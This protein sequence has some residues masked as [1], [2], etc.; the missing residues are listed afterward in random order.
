MKRFLIIGYP[1]GHTFSPKMHNLALEHYNISGRYEAMAIDPGEF[2]QAME[3]LKKENISGFNITVPYKQSILNHLDKVNPAAAAIG[4]V[5]TV[6]CDREG[7]WTGYNTDIHGFLH[8]LKS[9]IPELKS[10]LI[11]G[12]GGAARAVAFALADQPAIKK[13]AILNRTLSRAKELKADL[14]IQM[15]SLQI[16]CLSGGIHTGEPYD[17]IVNTSSVGMGSL[18]GKTPLTDL[19]SLIHGG[20]VVYDL[21]YNPAETLLLREA[22]RLGLQTLNGLP[23]LIEQ[24]SQA[25]YLWTGHYFPQKVYDIFS[26]A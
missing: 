17:L 4:A 5:N 9:N 16:R 7:K 11:L 1:L 19:P 22:R 10:C 18:S 24:G 14:E 12:A 2:D 3:T 15:P 26:S 8:P 13:M 6:V 21:I 23:M 20:T 25:F